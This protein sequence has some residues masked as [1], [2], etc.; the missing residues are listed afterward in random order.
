LA[1]G[2]NGIPA[3][4]PVRVVREDPYKQGILYAGTE[5][6]M[7]ISF[8]NGA[9]WQSL[10][11][12]LPATPVTDIK[13]HRKDLVLSTMGRS[14]WVMDDITPLHQLNENLMKTE[15]HLFE[16]RDAYR[17]RYSGFRLRPGSPEYPSPGV[18]IS[19]Y[20]A[21]DTDKQVDIKISDGRGNVIRNYS[22]KSTGSEKISRRAGMHRITWDL[23]YP[24]PVNLAAA[25]F[26]D[27]GPVVVPGTY[28]AQLSVGGWNT[29]HTF[30]VIMDPRVAEDGVTQEDLESQLA[31]NLQIRETISRT[32]H[33]VARIRSERK[34]LGEKGT[35][36]NQNVQ[37]LVNELTA[38]EEKLIQTKKGR[39]GSQLKP[40]L[41]RQLTY[42]YGMTTQA[43]QRPGDDAFQRLQ[44]IE[45]ELTKYLIRLERVLELLQDQS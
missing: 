33:A 18:F 9:H 26:R 39:I 28:T 20:L 40:K 21:E 16:P 7:F 15:A 35:E 30:R 37:A 36:S 13:V 44:D 23:R 17:M 42:L 27:N 31:L 2:T 25:R 22:S 6:G 10:Q 4:Y 12:D 24:A 32:S 5:F 8:D 29:S 45:A 3:D 43:D 19:Y 41:L 1:N 34:K 14:F 11:L 38:I